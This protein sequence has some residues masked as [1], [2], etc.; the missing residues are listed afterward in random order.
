[1]SQVYLKLVFGDSVR[2]ITTEDGI[3]MFSVYDFINVVC[4]K[5]DPYAKRVWRH[6][7]GTSDFTE[8]KED[9]LLL[10]QTQKQR[11]IQLQA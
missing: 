6:L 4:Q 2:G 8:V 10:Y 3:H 11:I 7:K 1:M 5:T 9:I